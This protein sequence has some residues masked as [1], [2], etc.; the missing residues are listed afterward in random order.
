MKKT[1]TYT[2]KVGL[3]TL[4]ASPILSLII[5]YTFVGLVFLLKPDNFSINTSINFVDIAVLTG[6]STL[7]LPFAIQKAAGSGPGVYNKK[8]QI[9][10]STFFFSVPLFCI[11]LFTIKSASEHP[12]G[13]TLLMVIPNL[14]VMMLCIRFYKLE[15]GTPMPGVDIDE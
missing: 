9:T 15:I 13:N 2:L 14:F 3:T 7:V 1:L 5:M 4:F 12:L 8:S 11:Y 6:I 10:V